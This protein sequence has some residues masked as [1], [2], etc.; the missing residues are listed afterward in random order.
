MTGL[1]D[2][3]Y[4]HAKS[5]MSLGYLVQLTVNNTLICGKVNTIEHPHDN[6]LAWLSAIDGENQV[7][8]IGFTKQ[9]KNILERHHETK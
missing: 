9:M 6:P 1:Q 3:V 7:K 4:E 5:L 2:E 8:V